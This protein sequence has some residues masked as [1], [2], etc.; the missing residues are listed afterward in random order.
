MC[1]T[2]KA[3]N[4]NNPPAPHMIIMYHIMPFF[5]MVNIGEP[6]QLHAEARCHR[7]KA[8]GKR[9]YIHRASFLGV[10]PVKSQDTQHSQR[11]HANLVEC[12][13]VAILKF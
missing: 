7:K 5:Q 11:P 13:T 12:S 3:S 4:K 8:C 1:A 6:N 10:Q 9:L 2:E